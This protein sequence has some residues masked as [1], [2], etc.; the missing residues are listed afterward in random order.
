M[1]NKKVLIAVA[2]IIVV[3][4]IIFLTKNHYKFSKTGNNIINKSADEIKNYILSIESYKATATITIE[5]N[6]NKNT[7][8]VKQKCN[9]QENVYKQE[10]LEPADIAGIQFIYDGTNLKIENTRLKLSKIYENYNYIGNNEL[11]LIAFIQEFGDGKCYEEN[12]YTIL[13]TTANQNNKYSATKKLYINKTTGKIERMEIKDITQNT[14]IYILYNEIEI[15]TTPKEEILAFS[16]KTI[17][18][19]I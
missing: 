2:L 6:K 18:Q 3:I 14:R 12:E 19:D 1:K 16:I 10:I 13:E 15:N 17:N 8:K 11:S 9:K 4:I 5:S 7:Y